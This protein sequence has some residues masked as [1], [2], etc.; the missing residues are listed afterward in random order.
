MTDPHQDALGRLERERIVWLCTLRPDGSPHLAPV[1]FVY[2]PGTWWV[3][4]TEAAVKVRNIARDP[5]VS[6]ALDNPGE[7]PIVAEGRATLHR[8]RFPDATVAAFVAKYA[9]DIGERSDGMQAPV[10][11]EVP[12]ARWLFGGT[13]LQG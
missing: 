7:A 10:L 3:C 4:T 2:Q 8:A 12:V 5:R 6:L 9:W 11:I 1:W 13:A